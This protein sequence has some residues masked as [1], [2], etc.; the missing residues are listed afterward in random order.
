MDRLFICF[1][2]VGIASVAAWATALLLLL[3]FARSR[4]RTRA[5]IAAFALSVAG[6]I[7][8]KVNSQSISKIE[9]DR[10]AEE[11]ALRAAQANASK[12]KAVE[13]HAG[14]PTEEPVYAYRKAGKQKRE[15]GAVP[16][17]SPDSISAPEETDVPPARRLPEADVLRADHYDRINLS[18]ARLVPW[19]ALVL[20]GYDYLSRFNRTQ[21]YPP[22]IP[23]AG[24]MVDAFCPKTR[25]VHLQVSDP[26]SL[27]AYLGDL[28]RKGETFLYLGE[29]DPLESELALCRWSLWKF[30]GGHLRKVTVDEPGF[31]TSEFVLDAA[32]FGRYCFVV[33]DS[34]ALRRL[35]ADLVGYLRARTRSRAAARRT[36][37]VVWNYPAPMPAETLTELAELCRETNFKLAIA[38]AGSPAKQFEALFEERLTL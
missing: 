12:G 11:A 23:I 38:A 20:L 33:T 4:R 13:P 35:L 9:V 37:H 31:P 17:G 7:L 10:T 18:C 19:L 14:E 24:R 36:V 1:G 26:T 30:R 28:V 22:P 5:C 2:V 32:W 29:S 25:V 34:R 3:A 21:G 15:V 8:A 6:F 16:A 27:R